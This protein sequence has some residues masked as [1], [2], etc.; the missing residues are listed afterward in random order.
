MKSEEII[1]ELMMVGKYINNFSYISGT[2]V[3]MIVYHLIRTLDKVAS[4]VIGEETVLERDYLT[5]SKYRLFSDMELEDD[6]YDIYFYLKNLMDKS[7][8]RVSSEAVRIIGHKQ[9]IT[10]DREFFTE[11]IGRVERISNDVA[12][13]ASK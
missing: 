12:S 4:Y 2:Q 13:H 3:K 11:L 6:F 10:A 8:L 5:L 9:T 1:S 7:I